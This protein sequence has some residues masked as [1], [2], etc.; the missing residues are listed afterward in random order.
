MEGRILSEAE[1]LVGRSLSVRT[2]RAHF[3]VY[4]KTVLV[5]VLKLHID[6]D[7]GRLLRVLWW[8]KEYPTDEQLRDKGLSPKNER[9]HR[10]RLLELLLTKL[11]EVSCC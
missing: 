4:L 7:L 2:F 1:E 8:L 11:P 10:W 5:I 9:D 6:A 3:G